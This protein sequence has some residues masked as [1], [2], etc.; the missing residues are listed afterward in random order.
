MS[1][2][3]SVLDKIIQHD[4]PMVQT[5]KT[6]ELPVIRDM[7]TFIGRSG[8][9]GINYSTLS[10]NLS[11]TKYK[12]RQYLELLEKAFVVKQIFPGGTNVMKEPKVLLALPYRLLFKD[13]HDAVGPL[14]EDFFVSAMNTAGYELMY[15]KSTRGSKTPDYMLKGDKSY[16]FEIGGPGKGRSRFKGI[17]ADK[18]IIFSHSTR[19]D[20]NTRPLFFLGFLTEHS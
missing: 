18:K 12:A 1:L 4:I 14:R 3:K 19:L 5:L 10:H 13:Y 15:L 9:D 11:I 8:V 6:D 17:Q 16:I 20:K 7:I 2:L